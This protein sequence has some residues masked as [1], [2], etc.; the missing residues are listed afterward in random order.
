MVE[1]R[2]Q[3]IR[4]LGH[5]CVREWPTFAHELILPDECNRLLAEA[6]ERALK[7]I[8]LLSESDPEA[9]AFKEKVY[10]G[11]RRYPDGYSTSELLTAAK[12]L[13]SSFLRRL[14]R[15][16][17]ADKAEARQ[18]PV[19]HS[20]RRYIRERGEFDPF[21]ADAN[22]MVGGLALPDKQLFKLDPLGGI[23]E[24]N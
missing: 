3:L 2:Q 19:S 21:M 6:H 10:G 12:Q 16:K 13:A 22:V 7:N 8:C 15:E 4:Y 23:V 18:D 1:A 17:A 24:E 5:L 14:Q 9:Q 11:C 20:Q